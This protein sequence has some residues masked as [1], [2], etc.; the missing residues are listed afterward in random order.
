MSFI[1]VYVLIANVIRHINKKII[2][3][4]TY[5][6]LIC[7]DIIIFLKYYIFLVGASFVGKERLHSEPEIF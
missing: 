3:D 1:N 4:F 5:F 7:D 6:F 2:E